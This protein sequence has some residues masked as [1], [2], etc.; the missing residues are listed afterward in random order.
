MY[1]ACAETYQIS[2]IYEVCCPSV[3]NGFSIPSDCMNTGTYADAQ[4][5]FE[6]DQ[7]HNEWGNWLSTS[8][9]KNIFYCSAGILNFNKL[10]CL[11]P[12]AGGKYES[13]TVRLCE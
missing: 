1:E 11:P 9:A 7:I 12:T 8:P 4:C 2:F 6:T 5:F 10:Q 3:S 13:G